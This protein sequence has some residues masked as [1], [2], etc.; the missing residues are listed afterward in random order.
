MTTAEG[1]REGKEGAHGSRNQREAA[2]VST[3]GKDHVVCQHPAAAETNESARNP[4]GFCDWV[5]MRRS[6]GDL[7]GCWNQQRPVQRQCACHRH[8]ASVCGKA[9]GKV[10]TAAPTHVSAGHLTEKKATAPEEQGRSRKYTSISE[11]VDRRP[12]F[13]ITC[14]GKARGA[15]FHCAFICRTRRNTHVFVFDHPCDEKLQEFDWNWARS[16]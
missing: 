3:E 2:S 16:S 10:L 12:H 13:W 6:P 5:V 8:S 1:G 11:S 14:C 4:A 15:P 7:S 9:R